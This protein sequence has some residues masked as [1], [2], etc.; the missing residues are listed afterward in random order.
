MKFPA[1]LTKNIWKKNAVKKTNSQFNGNLNME[2]K[3]HHGR[4]KVFIF[5]LKYKFGMQTV[6]HWYVFNGYVCLV[7]WKWIF[8]DGQGSALG[9]GLDLIFM[10][11]YERCISSKIYLSTTNKTE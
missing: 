6:I 3:F 11:L 4:Y 2:N 9:L 1:K 7:D 10:I 8:V 5:S